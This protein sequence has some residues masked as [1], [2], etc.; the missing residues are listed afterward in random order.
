[1]NDFTMT[2]Q[3]HPDRTVITV[4]G[5]MDLRTCPELAQAA[6]VVPLSGRT[7]HL[8]L[9]G[10]SFMDSS[11]LNLLVLLRRRLQAEDGRFAVA[12]LQ[13]QPARLLELTETYELLTADAPDAGRLG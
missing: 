7:L 3:Q 9:S 12:G 8:D 13:A 1:M 5:E 2:T 10:V 6:F 11:G 4:S